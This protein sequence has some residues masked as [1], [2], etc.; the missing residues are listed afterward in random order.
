MRL[1]ALAF[2]ERVSTV[3]TKHLDGA[4][5]ATTQVLARA[6]TMARTLRG[7]HSGGQATQQ[8][9]Q[10]RE[11]RR[12]TM[13]RIGLR[14]LVVLALCA[15]MLSFGLLGC[16][17]APTPAAQ[18]LS[19]INGTMYSVSNG[20]LP[21]LSFQL[22]LSSSASSGVSQYA[23]S[24]WLG[25]FTDTKANDTLTITPTYTQVPCFTTV[26]DPIILQVTDTHGQTAKA[27]V[28]IAIERVCVT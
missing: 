7:R 4:Q 13:S 28:T 11:Q 15:G 21:R 25:L 23:W 18:I 2:T 5:A 26:H 24:D 17:K 6:A 1:T 9:A 22:N 3:S 12:T 10:G 19:P 20:S 16:A 14:L 27:S 8:A